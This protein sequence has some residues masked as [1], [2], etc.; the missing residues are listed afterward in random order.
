MPARHA[1][2]LTPLEATFPKHILNS[3]QIATI[4]YSESTLTSHPQLVENAAI[5]T[6]L[7]CAFTRLSAGTLLNATL[8]KNTGVGPVGSD[9]PPYGPGSQ[10][11][12]NYPTKSFQLNLF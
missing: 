4:T 1:V 11:G 6:P 10:S 12:Q 8:T 5:L 9:F 7:E 3:K 2:L